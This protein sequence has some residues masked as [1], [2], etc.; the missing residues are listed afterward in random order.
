MGLINWIK[1]KGLFFR[2]VPLGD[3]LMV[4]LGFV[5]AFNIR[6][7]GDIPLFNWEPFVIVLPWLCIGVVVLFAALGM[8]EQKFYSLT[9]VAGLCALGI[10]GVSLLTIALTFWFREF[11]FPRSV[12]LIAFPLQVILVCL[13]RYAVWKLEL[14]WVGRKKL[15]VVGPS[16]EAGQLAIDLSEENNGGWFWLD[17]IITPG[18]LERLPESLAGAD[19][20]L[21]SP[22][23][24]REEKA[25][26]LEVCLDA[27]KEVFVVPDMYDILLSR[28]RLTSIR[29]L[30][31]VQV[32]DMGLNPLQA[33]IKRG[34]DFGVALTGLIA[35][36][37]L[38]IICAVA[39]KVSSPGPVIYKQKRVG[40]LGKNFY[41][42][43]FR[44]MV[45]GAEK[46][47]GPVLSGGNDPR[48]TKVGYY[49]RGTRLD[50]LPQLF[51]ILRGDMSLVGP[52]PERP[53]FSTQYVD[54]IPDYARRYLVR[55][56]LTGLAQIYGKY[57]TNP[58][59]KLRYDLYY[60]RNYSFFLD[61]KIIL[62]TLPIFLYFES[63]V[64]FPRERCDWLS[65]VTREE[66]KERSGSGFT[67]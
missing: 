52:R 47:T 5:I 8:Y 23:L 21:V 14:L 16:Y 60:I 42:Y 45:D 48:V 62:R 67:L 57:S 50:E 49:M 34:F 64:K 31:V 12:I 6:Y 56:G 36:W 66:D 2:L 37:P 39:V 19:G 40:L 17:K 28:G 59:D 13:W 54:I 53:F 58:E 46:H 27:G 44:T 63:A 30:P 65:T 4:A 20:V 43:K 55:P 1:K 24:S 38:F 25:V 3:P 29:D 11:S 41:M 9:Q 22:S 33:C 26:T 61:L 32:Q 15:L 18:E 7:A 10:I 35:L 51:N